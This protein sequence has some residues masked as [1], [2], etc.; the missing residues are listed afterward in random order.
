MNKLL[1]YLIRK[2]K[3]ED[4]SLDPNIPLNYLVRLS[5]KRVIM[6]IRGKFSG[7]KNGG[8]LFIGSS[9]IIKAKSLI[10]LG[11]GV[12]IDDQSYV[13]ALSKDGIKFGNNVSVG[14]RTIIECTGNIR[15]LGK[16]MV[17][18][19]NA[20]L[21]TDSFYGCAGGIRIGH[22]TIV[23]NFVSFHSEN[24]NYKD[25]LIPIRLQGVNHK[26]IQIGNNCWIG[27]KATILD[28]STIEDGCIIAA[29]ALVTQGTYEANGIYGGVPARLLKK[30]G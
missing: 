15:T 17:V 30:R 26:G 6:L 14:K 8:L 20:G 13:D 19:D 10:V 28:G 21:G 22:D 27:A 7:I 16:G 29:G 5:L 25:L 2:I 24:H 9:A 1:K 23:G 18:G 11:R 4:Y 12:T 3:N